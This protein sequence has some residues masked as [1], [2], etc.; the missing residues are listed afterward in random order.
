MVFSR[1]ARRCMWGGPRICVAQ[2]HPGLHL[3]PAPGQHPD[4]VAPGAAR[5]GILTPSLLPDPQAQAGGSPSLPLWPWLGFRLPSFPE[6]GPHTAA[7]APSSKDRQHSAAVTT[8]YPPP[9]M[10]GCWREIK[11]DAPHIMSFLKVHF[12]SSAGL[13]LLMRWQNASSK[14]L[15]D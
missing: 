7:P 14:R 2:R 3:A 1:G 6:P 10:T 9:F 15:H 12:R 8:G 5:P 13:V 11:P 4:A